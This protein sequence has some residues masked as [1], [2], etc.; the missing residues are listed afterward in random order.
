MR[1]KHIKKPIFLYLCVPAVLV[2]F[3]YSSA[4]AFVSGPCSDC[5]TMHNSVEN[6]PVAQYY[7]ASTLTLTTTAPGSPAI[8]SLLKSDCVVCHSHASASTYDLPGGATVPVVYTTGAPAGAVTAGGNFY[9]T[10]PGG[11][12]NNYGHNVRGIADQDTILRAPGAGSIGCAGS[13][14]DSLTFTD[15]NTTPA[16]GSG[17]RTNG[18]QGCHL[19]VGHHAKNTGT[20]GGTIPDGPGDAYRFLSGHDDGLVGY[21]RNGQGA[22]EDDDWELTTTATSSNLYLAQ[23]NNPEKHPY[24]SIGRWCAGC[25]AD[26]HAY[27]AVEELTGLSNG[28]DRVIN[29]PGINPWLR[30][31]TNVPLNSAAMPGVDDWDWVDGL[32]VSYDPNYPVARVNMGRPMPPYDA[33]DQVMCLT[34][35]KAHASEFPNSLR[36]AYNASDSTAHTGGN[37]TTGC[38]FCHR[39]KDS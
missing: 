7:D 10:T 27:G 39:T 32:T 21:V 16:S 35:H 38:F 36:W 20:E 31:P 5:H 17:V 4:L 29:N 37:R 13:C 3:A 34:C 28:G 14:H 25:H 1:I 22:W 9:Y 19:K 23:A 18:C 6:A 8:E 11:G 33:S 12:G 30:H 15:A 2:F 26:F 24:I